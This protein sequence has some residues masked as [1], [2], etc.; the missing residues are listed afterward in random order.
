MFTGLERWLRDQ[1]HLLFLQ[2]TSIQFPAPTPGDTDRQKEERARER[3][4]EKRRDRERWRE[5]LR[6]NYFWLL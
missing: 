6:I 2:K 3:Q 1:E 5:A 4:R